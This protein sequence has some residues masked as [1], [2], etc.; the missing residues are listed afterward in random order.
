MTNRQKKEKSRK[1][2]AKTTIKT[3]QLKGI[4]KKKS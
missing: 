1:K 2:I 4:Y 3:Q